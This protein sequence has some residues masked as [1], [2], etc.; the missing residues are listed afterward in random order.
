[1][2]YIVV[3]I[4]RLFDRLAALVFIND[5]VILLHVHEPGVEE[6]FALVAENLAARIG[7]LLVALVA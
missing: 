4:F 1:L 7:K 2:Q 5:D 6:N 3:A